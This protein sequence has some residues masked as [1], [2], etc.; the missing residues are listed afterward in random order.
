VIG[1]CSAINA[2]IYMRGQAQDYDQWRQMGLTGWGW[3]DV[4]P[5]FMQHEDHVAPFNALHRK[6]GEW[7]VDYRACVGDP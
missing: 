3:D 2:M 7:S 4:L 1:G 6:G 5:Y